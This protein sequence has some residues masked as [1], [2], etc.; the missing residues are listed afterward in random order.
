MSERSEN[1]YVVIVAALVIGFLLL[2]IGGWSVAWSEYIATTKSFY[3][4]Y[5]VAVEFNNRYYG[6]VF[7][8]RWFDSPVISWIMGLAG[9]GSLAGA[10]SEVVELVDGEERSED[11]AD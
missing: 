11:V 8:D 3:L 2:W 9:V 5:G 6:F 10:A 7:G 1:P 4:K